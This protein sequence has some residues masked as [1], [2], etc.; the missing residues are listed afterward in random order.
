MVYSE[1]LS[2][3]AL[4]ISI[5]SASGVYVAPI[6]HS[7]F[8]KKSNQ[9][10]E[11]KKSIKENV[12]KPLIHGINYFIRNQVRIY[13]TEGI[14]SLPSEEILQRYIRGIFDFKITPQTISIN[15]IPDENEWFDS[16]LYS[17]FK[18]HNSKLYEEIEEVESYIKEKMPIHVKKRWRLVIDIYTKIK[19][20]VSDFVNKEVD[21]SGVFGVGEKD[22]LTAVSTKVALLRLLEADPASTGLDSL[23]SRLVGKT[24]ILIEIEN[25]VSDKEFMKKAEKLCEVE[26]EILKTLSDLRSDIN[27]EATSGAKL[28][29]KCHYLGYENAEC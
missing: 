18:C 16:D 9:R 5:I 6:I 15:D 27:R 25:I 21:R 1:L 3:I 26:N 7:H 11:H 17:D 20:T 24:E 29:G 10:E 8:S 19:Q 4:V 12:L 23:S 28:K 14:L 13:L 22:D 2:I